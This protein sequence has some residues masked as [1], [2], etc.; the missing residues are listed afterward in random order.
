MN[1]AI[2][3]SGLGHVARGVEAWAADLGRALAERG[4]SVLLAKAAG[5]WKPT[6]TT[7]PNFTDTDVYSPGDGAALRGELGIPPDALVVL[8]VAAI[9]RSHKRVDHLLREFAALRAARPEL[10][11]WLVVAGA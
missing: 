8:S 11:V 4:E 9:K 7:I 10:P 2:A 1:I 3:S 6:W 5:C